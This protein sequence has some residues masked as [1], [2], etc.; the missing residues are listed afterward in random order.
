MLSCCS[1]ASDS[2]RRGLL[3]GLPVECA[4]DRV[5][6]CIIGSVVWGVLGEVVV[7]GGG[8]GVKGGV[9]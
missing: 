2:V 3:G 9:G 1:A 8:V 4:G 7:W 5:K 6:G